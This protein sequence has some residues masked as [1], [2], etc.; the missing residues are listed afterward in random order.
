MVIRDAQRQTLQQSK[1][2]D[3]VDRLMTHFR[4]VW[5]D[6][7]TALGP[8]YRDWIDS[9][10]VAASRYELNTEQE[11]ARFVN[12]W[13]VWGRA[14]ETLPEHRWAAVILHDKERKSHV[15]IHQLSY[16]TKMRLAARKED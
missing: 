15:K 4:K 5:P 2:D 9:A 3:F 14:F 11:T 7:A 10:V 12:L 8:G 13:F 16:E 1:H 6:K